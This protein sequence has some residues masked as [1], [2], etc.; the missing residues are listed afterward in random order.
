MAVPADAVSTPLIAA[1]PATSVQA[2]QPAAVSGMLRKGDALEYALT[3]LLTGNSAKVL[4][5]VDRLSGDEISFNGGGRI[6]KLNGEVVSI[7]NPT[8][9]YFDASSPPGGW[10]RPGLKQGMQ[11]QAVYLLNGVRHELQATVAGA[12]TRKVDGIGLTVQRIEWT[13]WIYAAGGSSSP[14]GSRLK[15]TALY[16]EALGRVVY[17][18]VDH[19]P[20][21]SAPRRESLELVRIWR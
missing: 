1:V 21:F 14:V 17:F 13:G 4:Y 19:R 16:A 15:A 11:W 6:E 18:E 7:R 10:G 5:N 12:A 2:A 8:G 20:A 3:D 9:G